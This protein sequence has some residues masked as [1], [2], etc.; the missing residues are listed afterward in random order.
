MSF[1]TKL[2]DFLGE[3][4]DVFTYLSREHGEHHWEVFHCINVWKSLEEKRLQV[5]SDNSKP[6]EE[7]IQRFPIRGTSEEN[8]MKERDSSGS[9][10]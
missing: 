3:Y 6:N 2:I 5:S 4:R 10:D 9:A 1:L 8:G 7:S